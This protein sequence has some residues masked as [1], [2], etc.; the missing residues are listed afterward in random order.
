MQNVTI[1]YKK[2]SKWD[3]VTM[4]RLHHGLWVHGQL[5]VGIHFVKK[6]SIVVWESL[7]LSFCLYAQ[8]WTNQLKRDVPY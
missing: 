6:I 3:C 1:I 5:F 2:A 4:R 8:K 7:G